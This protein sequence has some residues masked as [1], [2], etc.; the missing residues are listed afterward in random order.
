MKRKQNDEPYKVMGVNLPVSMIHDLHDIA[1]KE[2]VD[3][4]DLIKTIFADYIRVHGSGNPNYHITDF[5][6]NTQMEALSAFMR[7]D[8]VWDDLAASTND[9]K[10]ALNHMNKGRYIA[11]CF[12]KRLTELRG[13]K[14]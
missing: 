6:D 1:N 10:S 2:R 5:T 12:N 11:K 14:F 7:E 4:Q 3:K 9:E 8:K 13:W